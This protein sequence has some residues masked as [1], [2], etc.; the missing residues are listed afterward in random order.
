MKEKKE[1][2]KKASHRTV[3]WSN[4]Y[5]LAVYFVLFDLQYVILSSTNL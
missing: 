3:I 2:G 1:G 5:E 4:M